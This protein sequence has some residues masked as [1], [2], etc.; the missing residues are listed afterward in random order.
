VARWPILAAAWAIVLGTVIG[1]GPLAAGRSEPGP[2]GGS[3]APDGGNPRDRSILRPERPGNER[4]LERLDDGSFAVRD[5]WGRR[6]GTVER[7]SLG[8]YRYR[9]QDHRPASRPPK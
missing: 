9:E 1:P 3:A 2:N 5:G 8:N 7:D 6:L 4:Y